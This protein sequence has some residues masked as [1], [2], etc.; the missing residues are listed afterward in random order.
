MEKFSKIYPEISVIVPL[1]NSE[2]WIRRCINSILAQTFK[3]YEVIL[4]DDGSKDGSGVLCD[5]LACENENVRV[6]HQENRGLAAARKKGV[7]AAQGKYIT[8]IDSDDYVAPDMLKVLYDN[9]SSFDVVSCCYNVVNGNNKI[10]PVNFKEEYI[11]FFDSK[12]MIYAYFER[13]YLHGTACAKLAKRDLYDCIDMCEGAAPGEEICTT[14]QLYQ[15]AK[16]ARALSAPLYYY[17]QNEDG[18]SHGGFTPLHRKGL[19]NYINMCDS[20]VERFPEIRKKIGVYFCEH[21][22]GIMT[23][24]CRND[25][26]DIEVIKMLQKHLKSHFGELIRSDSALYYKASALMIILNYKCFRF[27]FKRIRKRVGR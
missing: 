1:Y 10:F 15:L 23:A 19:I 17:W 24:M 14:L 25:I 12:E 13:Q 3:D 27:V 26:Y 18:I 16:S 7:E 11:D 21:E 6:V 8:F 9:I 2:K 5:S 20:L 4:I 22:M